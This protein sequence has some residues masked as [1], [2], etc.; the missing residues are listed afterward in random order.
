MQGVPS[1]PRTRPDELGSVPRTAAALR[2]TVV[3]IPSPR[4]LRT[5]RANTA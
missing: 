4:R 1:R 5:V 3:T 2:R